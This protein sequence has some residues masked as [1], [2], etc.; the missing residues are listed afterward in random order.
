MG[1]GVKA[2]SDSGLAFRAE[3]RVSFS[4]SGIAI[5]GKNSTAAVVLPGV[6]VTP[7]SFVLLTPRGN[8]GGR[9]LWYT[10]SPGTDR[11]TIRLSSALPTNLQVAWLLLG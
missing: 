2:A 4:T 7:A 6:D 5:I 1:T 3:G 11:F 8:L 10:I 9:D